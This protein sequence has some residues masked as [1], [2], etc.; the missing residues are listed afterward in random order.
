MSKWQ[1]HFL[2]CGIGAQ[3]LYNNSKSQNSLQNVKFAANFM[4]RR[5]L[6]CKYL[7]AKFI[8]S[9][10]TRNGLEKL[11]IA[12]K[13]SDSSGVIVIPP[14]RIFMRGKLK[15]EQSSVSIF[16]GFSEQQDQHCF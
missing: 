4:T 13:S 3:K 15:V 5:N 14:P 2:K 8:Y 1:V 6:N 10:I 16:V 9:F 12:L 11:L 7:L